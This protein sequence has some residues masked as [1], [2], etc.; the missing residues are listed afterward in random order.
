MKKKSNVFPMDSATWRIEDGIGAGC[1]YLY[2]LV[3]ESRGMLIDTGIGTIDAGRIVRELTDK[4][5]F[6]VNTHG[7]LDHISANHQ[8]AEAYLHPLDE[9][10]FAEH[11][12][13]AN[14]YAFAQGLM[15]EGGK[16]GWLL[17]LPGIRGMV[18]KIC[19]LPRRDNRKPLAEGQTFDL[20]NRHV[21]VIE[22]PGHTWGSVCLLDVERRWLFTGDTV[23]DLG[24]LLHLPHSAPVET[25]QA[26]IEKLQGFSDR[27]DQMWPGHHRVPLEHELLDQY[28]ACA[29][30]IRQGEKGQTVTSAAG[31]GQLLKHE[32]ISLSF[33][34][35]DDE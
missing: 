34:I 18:K 4:P 28:V 16:P 8:F 29:R 13:Y 21:R 25:F 12:N 32:G 23:C 2:L 33:Q 1:A 7:H 6:A 27:F 22:T 11:S 35:K 10:V 3:G 17:K 24:V 31:T 9:E 15:A 5:V 19:D 14:R 26:S 20:G 30:R